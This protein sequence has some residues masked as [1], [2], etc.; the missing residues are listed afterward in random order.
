[1]SDNPNQAGTTPLMTPAQHRKMAGLL[2]AK[3]PRDP[4]TP[5]LAAALEQ[6]AAALERRGQS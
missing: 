3:F 6:I 4:Q 5:E 2:R 1:M